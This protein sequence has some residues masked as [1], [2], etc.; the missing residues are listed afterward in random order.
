MTTIRVPARLRDEEG[1]LQ[2]VTVELDPDRL[3]PRARAWAQARPD[4]RVHARLD[5]I[6]LRPAR[7]M[8]P[9][10]SS[11]VYAGD[12]DAPIIRATNADPMPLPHAESD[13]HEWA[14]IQ[15]AMLPGAGPLWRVYRGGHIGAQLPATPVAE[16]DA[17]MTARQIVKS[18]PGPYPCPHRT[19]AGW[20]RA[21]ECGDVPAPVGISA[22]HLLWDPEE[23]WACMPQPARQTPQTA[24]QHA[25][26][27]G[28]DRSA[29]TKA[30][31]RAEAAGEEVPEPDE[32]D[33]HT[34]QRRWAPATWDSWWHARRRP[35]RPSTAKN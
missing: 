30:L 15:S 16:T 31:A 21:A 29:I 13:P 2:A 5:L 4:A 23:V 11:T 26:R 10:P 25:R 12:P 8:P 33:Q 32:T 3:S 34:G 19:A 18:W 20:L 17:R 7:D 27:L 35:G 6:S 28:V 1:R 14:E 24:A 9:P 22:G